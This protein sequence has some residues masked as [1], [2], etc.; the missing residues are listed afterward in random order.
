MKL[1]PLFPTHVIAHDL[2]NYSEYRN[3]LIRYCYQDQKDSD[4]VK[5]SNRGGWQ[6]EHKQ[7][8]LLSGVY[9]EVS[10]SLTSYLVPQFAFSM[11]WI[12]INPPGTSNE[13]HTHPGSDL[14]VV[15]Y[16]KVPENSGAIEMTN[17]AYIESFNLLSSVR[18]EANLTPSIAITPLEGRVLIFPSNILH[19]VLENES[20]DD[21][22]S[23]SWNVKVL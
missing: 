20:D 17:P 22:I 14:S 5:I 10:E 13:R 23:I 7:I 9:E 15:M 6:S 8:D 1:F 2:E 3:K 4:G 12:N 19:R 11:P 18:P 16:V 21:R